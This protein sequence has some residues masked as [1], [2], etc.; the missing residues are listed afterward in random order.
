[1]VVHAVTAG[2]L[3]QAAFPGVFAFVV[4]SVALVTAVPVVAVGYVHA[5][6]TE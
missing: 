6:G 5:A 3:G 1:L 2:L 4:N